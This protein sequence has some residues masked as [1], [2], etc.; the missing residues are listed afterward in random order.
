[1]ASL[2]VLGEGLSCANTKNS[3]K[4]L[5]Q[6]DDTVFRQGFGMAKPARYCR[7]L[8]AFIADKITARKR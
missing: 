2:Q 6:I 4:I 8:R 5:N 1:M 3:S 7:P